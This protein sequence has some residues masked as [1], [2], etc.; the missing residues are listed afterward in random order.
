MG[1]EAIVLKNVS[2]SF[3][4]EAVLKSVN[5]SC[6]KGEIYGV[7]GRNGSGKTVLLKIICG[8]M[9]PDE[10]EVNVCGKQIGKDCDF[11]Q[12]I[13]VVIEHPGFLKGKSGFENL[14]YLAKIKK[15]ITDREICEA[16]TKVGL[17]GTDKKKVGKY[18]M[19]MRQRLGI[20]QA[21]M[22]DPEVLL[23][24]EPINGLDAQCT[25]KV[26]ELLLE[27][28]EKGKVIILVSHNKEDI[29]I[30]CDKVYE[31]HDGE[32]RMM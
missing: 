22:E 13:G 14:K 20:A 12:S 19:G 30:L 1:E 32:L 2:K 28:K 11:P 8:L 15:K 3:G 29:S 16:M 18:S 5:L 6:Q 17:D 4:N 7:C 31:I 26:R 25:E 24:D 21:I 9:K 27:L 10:G 23:L